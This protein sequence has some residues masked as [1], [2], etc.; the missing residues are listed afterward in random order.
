MHRQCS[1]RAKG[2][3]PT[4]R[5]C[6]V[7]IVQSCIYCLPLFFTVSV[8]MLAPITCL[9]LS[10]QYTL[11]FKMHIGRNRSALHYFIISSILLYLLTPQF[12]GSLTPWPFPIYYFSSVSFSSVCVLINDSP[13]HPAFSLHVSIHSFLRFVLFCSLCY[14]RS[15][16]LFRSQDSSV[17]IAIQVRFLEVQHFLFS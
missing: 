8:Y 3:N 15:S 13:N 9:D 4:S 14:F 12:C 10:P 1:I 16:M 5:D 7:V 6:T 2:R 17:G 11:H